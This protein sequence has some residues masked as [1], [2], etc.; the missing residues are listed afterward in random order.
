MKKAIYFLLSSAMIITGCSKA[1]VDV[2]KQVAKQVVIS[3]ETEKIYD[4]EMNVK[5][6]IDKNTGLFLWETKDVIGI[7]CKN[8]GGNNSFVEFHNTGKITNAPSGRNEFSGQISSTDI[9]GTRA[10]YPVSAFKD[11]DGSKITLTLPQT[12][13]YSPQPPL[14]LLACAN[15]GSTAYSLKHLGGMIQFRFYGVPAEASCVEFL[16]DVKITGDFVIDVSTP[17]SPSSEKLIKSSASTSENKVTITDLPAPGNFI[18]YIPV[19]TGTIG[20]F[21][22]ALKDAEGNVIP[23][24][25]K[26][27]APEKTFPIARRSM[28]VIP[29]IGFVPTPMPDNHPFKRLAEYNV[30]ET[31]GVFSDSHDTDKSGYFKWTEAQSAC[32]DGYRIPSKEE[33]NAFCPSYYQENGAY[34]G[35]YISFKN[36]KS[37]KIIG[38]VAYKYELRGTIKDGSTDLT[39]C[40]VITARNLGTNTV[41]S[42]EIE[43]DVFWK[44]NKVYDEVKYLPLCG[45]KSAQGI[46][47][48]RGITAAYHTSTEKSGGSSIAWVTH[49]SDRMFYIQPNMKT[50]GATVRCIKN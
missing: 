42:E 26:R 35:S 48:K 50:L 39:A 38:G 23:G 14:Y 32:P 2:T 22:V 12:Y 47:E 25:V 29:A 7:E 46:L 33:L 5:T 10:V 30:S 27:T 9:L 41:S 17:Y 13:I 31:S 1:E 45:R 28:L 36:K 34:V 19:P 21:K 4:G 44:S 37:Y 24:F 20:N 11:F 16:T 40:L 8:A 43:N 18:V 15:P 3:A 49:S 6:I